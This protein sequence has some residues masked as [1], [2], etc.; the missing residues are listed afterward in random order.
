MLHCRNSDYDTKILLCYG[1]PFHY[2]TAILLHY[3][4]SDRYGIP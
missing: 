3:Q 4:D 2:I 1:I